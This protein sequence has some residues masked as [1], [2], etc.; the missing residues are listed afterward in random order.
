MKYRFK[1][2]PIVFALV[3]GIVILGIPA[4][5]MAQ[6]PPQEAID[7][8]ANL[9]S[10]DAC[11]FDDDNGTH[12]GTCET[13]DSSLACMP[14]GQGTS[15]ATTTPVATATPQSGATAT[16]STTGISYPIIDTRQENCYDNSGTV[17]V[18]PIVGEAYYGQ[19]AQYNG[20]QPSYTNN[21][22]GTVSDNITGLMWQKSPDNSRYDYN[23]SQTYCS[24]LSVGS[25]SDWRIPTIKELYSLADF[26][27]ELL[28]GNTTTSTPYIDRTYFDFEYPTEA[29]AGQY[30]SI[31][32]YVKGPIVNDISQGVF[33]FNFADGHIKS[34]GAGFEFNN[35]SAT[36]QTNG[37]YVY[38]VRGT[39][40]QYGINDFQDNEDSTITDKATNLMWQQ[41]DDGT[42][43]NWGDSLSYCEGLSLANH[44]DWRLPNV[45]ELQSIVDYDKTDYPAID[46]IFT[47][48]SDE[49][50][51][52][53]STTHGDNKAYASYVAFGKAYS[54][55]A[56][57]TDYTD[58][59]GAGAQRSDPKSGNASDYNLCSVNACDLVRVDNYAR[60]V[61][62]YSSASATSTPTSTP[63][64]AGG[65]DQATATNT[66]VGGTDQPT[67]TNTPTSTPTPAAQ[68]SIYEGY[69]LYSPLQS[70]Q[71][72][73]MDNSGN[74]VY[75][76][77]S[78]YS[79]ALSVYL[80]DDG[81]LLH[82]GNMS[83]QYFTQTMGSPPSR[84]PSQSQTAS[85]GGGS[86]Q[87]IDQNNNVVWEYEYS[88][89]TYL[90]HH[91]VEMLPNGNLLILAW[92]KKTEAE[93]IAAGRNSTL[94]AD[95]ELWVEHLIEV[96][97][98]KD[99]VW[100]WYLWD[101]LIQDHDQSKPNFGTVGDHPELVDL[102]YTQ[103]GPNGSGADWTHANSV[104]YNA[105]FDQIMLSVHNFSEIWIIDH[106][107]TTAESATH[108]GGDRGK[109][110]D[111]LYR[112]GNPQT[113]DAGTSTDQKLFAQHDARW[114]L[115]GYSGAGNILVFNNG[116]G[117]S[118]GNIST[119]DEIVP[120]VD[121][122]GNYTAPAAGSAYEPTDQ[123]WVYSLDSSLYSSNISGAERL[124]NGNTLICSG[125]NGT[126]LEVT[127]DKQV[128]W[129][130]EVTDKEVFRVSRHGTDYAG[131]PD[132]VKPSSTSTPTNT[133][134]S[135]TPQATD[136]PSSGTPQATDTPSSGTPQATD[137]PS[138]GTPQATDTPSSG[139]PQAS[140]TPSSGTPQATDTPSS[141]TGTP[142]ATDTPS[143]GTPQATD[144]PSSG[145]STPQ[146]TSTLP[147][148]QATSTV[149]SP[150][151]GG[152][153]KSNDAAQ[154]VTVRFPTN[155]VDD[156]TEVAFEWQTHNPDTHPLGDRIGLGLFFEL[157]AKQGDS[158]VETFNDQVEIRVKI[159][160][161]ASNPTLYFWKNGTGWSNEG[162]VCN[163]TD[164]EL[165]CT[166]DH[167]T[168]FAVL[169]EAS[170]KVYLPLVV[171]DK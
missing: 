148:G 84:Q 96:N 123:T 25:Y 12:S 147:A 38:C 152:T 47:T 110:G 168:M 36:R 4:S 169:D 155:S 98:N 61:R 42:T 85:G 76:W 105:N 18:C 104:D 107:T 141:G 146:P 154:Q 72:Y 66:P 29:Y 48:T 114:I 24:S 145:T 73:L 81:N 153:L 92:E 166:T 102:N 97:S 140:G 27:G 2:Q 137:T 21:G 150:S 109:G 3:L 80:L 30:A 74:T 49:S 82:T 17:I 51:F 6:G 22:D 75:T 58:W 151:Q 9:S 63:T 142:Q 59:H 78:N 65:T 87:K 69:N 165:V 41:A 160:A 130:H 31:S 77:D 5:I 119:V 83:N 129:Q 113:Y 52:W 50:W 16:P 68:G 55:L 11:E 135:G 127:S 120:D 163:L 125:A 60:C 158:L 32:L 99:I 86:I 20:I 39:E 134:S 56:D 62:D 100:E 138:S 54:K 79:P 45:K 106:G 164:T 95:G 91:D 126:F 23:A 139:T 90:Q 43:R 101:H 136:T 117:R 143:S 7:A 89:Q 161:N 14:A 116:Q 93:A 121:G 132:S 67:A 37:L 57:A 167:F 111:L 103:G 35:P 46:D 170:Y 149:V 118:E 115:D 128:V 88:S 1:M 144:T 33:G 8:C 19:D 13:A 53:T 70:K 112:W 108:T 44:T 162:L 15:Q 94:V 64:P 159:P 26:R 133:P 171:K 124:P 40:N 10:G 156:D 71:T 131:L 34:Y 122:S 157:T 28:M